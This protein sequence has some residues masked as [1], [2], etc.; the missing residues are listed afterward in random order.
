MAA[1]KGNLSIQGTGH[2]ECGHRV[3][4]FLGFRNPETGCMKPQ[5]EMRNAVVE[6]PECQ[7]QQ[8]VDGV[9]TKP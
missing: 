2:A 8:G 7:Q 9:T 4:F 5:R 3:Q 6:L 1:G